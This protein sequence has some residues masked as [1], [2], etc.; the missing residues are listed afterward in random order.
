MLNPCITINYKITKHREGRSKAA[1]DAHLKSK[2][3]IKPCGQSEILQ[4]VHLRLCSSLLVQ[5]VEA[6]GLGLPA[7]LDRG[8]DLRAA[9]SLPVQLRTS[10]LGGR[11]NTPS[12]WTDTCMLM[13]SCRPPGDTRGCDWPPARANG[14]LT[15]NA[16]QPRAPDLKRRGGFNLSQ[17]SPVQGWTVLNHPSPRKWL[18]SRGTV[19]CLHLQMQLSAFIHFRKTTI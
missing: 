13:S 16:E 18:T 14:A 4:Y 19:Y 17:Q 6:V 1:C 11:V 15:D 2:C 12:D 7:W 5:S 3:E 8:S 9:V 10:R